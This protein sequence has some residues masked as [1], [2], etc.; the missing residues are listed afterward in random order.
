[1]EAVQTR[2]RDEQTLRDLYAGEIT[3]RKDAYNITKVV[4]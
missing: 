4:H 2:N 1:M 3:D